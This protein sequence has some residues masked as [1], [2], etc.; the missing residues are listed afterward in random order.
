MKVVSIVSAIFVLIIVLRI[1]VRGV[2]QF[3]E[4]DRSQ[5]IRGRQ[6]VPFDQQLEIFRQLRFDLNP[7]V[8]S[9]D[10]ASWERDDSTAEEQP[11]MLVYTMLGSCIEREPFTPITNRCW[12][13]DTEAIEDNGAYV[14]IIRNLERISRG[15]LTFTDVIDHVDIDSGDAWI[16]FIFNGQRYRWT[17]HVND[18]WVDVTLFENIVKLTVEHNTNGRFT[19]LYT[20][21]Q[22]ILLGFETEE[23]LAEIKRATGLP[24]EWLE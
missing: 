5:S 11:F 15:A 16:S 9:S 21:D 10:I 1:F 4:Q 2:R 7:E 22:T 14:D 24:I 13:F 18:D 19:S 12:S 23:T 17:M 3:N 20:G 8:D 6:Q